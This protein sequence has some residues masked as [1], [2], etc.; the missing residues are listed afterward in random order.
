[1]RSMAMVSPDC[2]CPIAKASSLDAATHAWPIRHPQGSASLRLEAATP[3]RTDV[4]QTQA[5]DIAHIFIG[6]CG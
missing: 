3:W 6:Y 4:T 5:N 2:P 1:M